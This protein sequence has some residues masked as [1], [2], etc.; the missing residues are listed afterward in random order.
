[1]QQNFFPLEKNINTINC[2]S[3]AFSN[4]SK[5]MAA[6][7]HIDVILYDV[8]T[9]NIKHTLEGHGSYIRDLRFS[10]CNKMLLSG[11]SDSKVILW[12]IE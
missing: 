6:G 10:N 9:F 4:D 5:L 12:D 7:N 2:L 11:S 1:M 8:D 3:V